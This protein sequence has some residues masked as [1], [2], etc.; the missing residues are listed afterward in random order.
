MRLRRAFTL[1]ALLLVA[2]V[3]AVQIRVLLAD[4]SLWPPD[5]F[6]EYWAAARLAL[7]G[8]NPYD[9]DQLLPLQRANG[10]DTDEA[11]MMWNPPWTLTVVWPL[12]LVPA[13]PAQLLWLGVN[14]AAVL[15]CGVRLWHRLGGRG[16][17]AWVGCA[18]ALLA[19]PSLFALQAGQISPLVL[20]GVV[21]F[22]DWEGRGRPWAAGAATVLTAVKPHLAYLVWP[23]ILLDA[24]A[25][26]HWRIVAGGL[27]A[28][29]VAA[30][31][32]LLFDPHVWRQYL[33]ALTGRPPEQWKSPTAGTVLRLAFGSEHFGLQF[34]PVMVGLAWFA[35]WAYRHRHGWDWAEQLPLLLLVSFVT[36]P[37]G[38]WPFDLVL[39][40]PAAVRLVVGG[41]RGDVR[42]SVV[43][44]LLAVNLGCLGLNLA[45]TGSFAFVWVA[46][47]VLVLYVLGTRTGRVPASAPPPRLVPA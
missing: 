19:L 10:R 23:A 6:I 45:R 43:G 18:V 26:N 7:T 34:A 15:F 2:V 47:A 46:P 39:L 42:W 11:V 22:L 21:L 38:A 8:G 12:G 16:D 20:L 44:G 41:T 33:E 30:A 4:P 5:D 3:L 32:P 17:R 27:V 29:M 13:R 28:G 35:G 40:L 9:P 24:V 1:L 31:V 36:T 37:Y 25:R 14:L